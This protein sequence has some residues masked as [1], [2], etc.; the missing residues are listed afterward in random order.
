L[1]L[2]RI[3]IVVPD[4]EQ[5]TVVGQLTDDVSDGT[6]KLACQ[7]VVAVIPPFFIVIGENEYV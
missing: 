3:V 7:I 1:V 2:L 5:I 6:V 4:S